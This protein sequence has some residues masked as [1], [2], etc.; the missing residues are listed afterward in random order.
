MVKSDHLG[1]VEAK[2]E[3]LSTDLI[4]SKKQ[5]HDLIRRNLKKVGIEGRKDENWNKKIWK[6][7]P[8][9]PSDATS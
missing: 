4:F 3:K 8:R 7:S 9:L 2:K 6:K 1:W 5:V